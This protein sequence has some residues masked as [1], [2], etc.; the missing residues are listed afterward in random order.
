MAKEVYIR[1]DEVLLTQDVGSLVRN[2]HCLAID[3]TPVLDD[4]CLSTRLPFDPF[5]YLK[6]MFRKDLASLGVTVADLVD[7][8]SDEDEPSLFQKVLPGKR[9][10]VC[11]GN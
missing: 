3:R 9:K 4:F 7:Q 10:I 6:D 11:L 1:E 8:L 2:D 5:A